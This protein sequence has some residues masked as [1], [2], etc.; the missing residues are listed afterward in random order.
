MP[1]AMPKR[2][3]AHAITDVLFNI[4]SKLGGNDEGAKGSELIFKTDIRFTKI[5]CGIER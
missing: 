2:I 5:I 1:L 4:Y 3:V